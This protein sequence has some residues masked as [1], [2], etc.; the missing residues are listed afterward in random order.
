MFDASVSLE[1]T[2]QSLQLILLV[3]DHQISP[4]VWVWPP[5]DSNSHLLSGL[6]LLSLR[7]ELIHIPICPDE[8]ASQETSLSASQPH[9]EVCGQLDYKT[10]SVGIPSVETRD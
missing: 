2:P 9:Q 6:N 7:L 4:H 5:H 10:A 3:H 1:G 8:P